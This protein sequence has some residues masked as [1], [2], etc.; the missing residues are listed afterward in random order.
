M[1]VFG[2]L[3]E[4]KADLERED[5]RVRLGVLLSTHANMTNLPF[6]DAPAQLIPAGNALFLYQAR[7][8]RMST[9][10]GGSSSPSSGV[11]NEDASKTLGEGRTLSPTDV[12]QEE[13][14]GDAESS[15][16]TGELGI[17]VGGSPSTMAAEEQ[18]ATSEVTDT[19]ITPVKASKYD[20]TLTKV[21]TSASGEISHV[22][23]RGV[24]SSPSVEEPGITS[25]TY[26]DAQEKTMEAIDSLGDNLSICTSTTKQANTC[27]RIEE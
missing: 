8:R 3:P 22:F 18:T 19:G 17:S 20:K 23:K 13:P 5:Q 10:S 14:S 1:S 26:T 9:S 21:Q 15:G 11:E 24:G 27:G 4:S 2:V 16:F 25:E 7:K 6:H 12:S